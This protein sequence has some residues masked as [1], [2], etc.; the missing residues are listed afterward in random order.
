M[1]RLDLIV[2]RG[3]NGAIGLKGKMPWHLPEDL[4]HFKETTMGSPVIMGRRTY[5]SIGRALPGRTNIVLTRDAS[6]KA[7]NVLHASSI[8]DALKLVADAPL[9]FIIGG[10][11]LYTQALQKNLISSAW[12][13]EIDAAPEADA[14]F[15]NL[16][17]KHWNRV[18]IKELDATD[19]RP[20]LTFC[21][22][23][24]LKSL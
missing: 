15:P 21:R 24:F 9:A 5:E 8:E 17:E 10:A 12:V 1:T 11:N 23:D 19:L 4:K 16:E 13:T 22:Y 18:V 20:K 6:F 3:T 14:F 7:T 2:A